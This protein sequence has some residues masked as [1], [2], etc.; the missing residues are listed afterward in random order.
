LGLSQEQL[1]RALGVSFQRVRR[2]E[3]GSNRVAAARLL[4]LSRVLDAPVAFF[5]DG[6][7]GVV[8]ASQDD[9]ADDNSEWRRH[10]EALELICAYWRIRS[11]RVRK[12]VF[13]LI[14]SIGDEGSATASGSS[15]A[16]TDLTA[17]RDQH[18]DD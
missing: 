8:V 2:Y 3:Q 11:K 17:E 7:P 9:H 5:F 16:D 14:K 6:L 18:G 13:E 15:A 12:R 4:D 10:A 1:A